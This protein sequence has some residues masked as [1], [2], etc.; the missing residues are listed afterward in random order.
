MKTRILHMVNSIFFICL[1]ILLS[2]NNCYAKTWIVP[3]GVPDP[4]KSLSDVCKKSSK[5]GCENYLFARNIYDSIVNNY[6]IIIVILLV[7]LV[8]LRV[9]RKWEKPVV[10]FQKVNEHTDKTISS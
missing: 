7:F 4:V 2:T 5:T 6:I 3:L 8:I 9:I 10:S 1:F